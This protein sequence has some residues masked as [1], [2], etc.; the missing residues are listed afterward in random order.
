MN[1]GNNGVQKRTKLLITSRAY[2]AEQGSGVHKKKFIYYQFIAK[3]YIRLHTNDEY[4]NL[5]VILT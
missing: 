3:Y 4:I 5:T 1:N 2:L